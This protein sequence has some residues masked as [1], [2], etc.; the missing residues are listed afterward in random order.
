MKIPHPPSHTHTHVVFSRGHKLNKC[1]C[2]TVRVKEKLHFLSEQLH[3]LS[4]CI[5]MYIQ[6]LDQKPDHPSLKTPRRCSEGDSHH[7]D[8]SQKAKFT[9]MIQ[10]KMSEAF[11]LCLKR[12]VQCY[13]FFYS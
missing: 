4:L 11:C 13:D 9:K 1:R 5:N 8:E 2:E 6:Y 10:L 12:R 7:S 3:F